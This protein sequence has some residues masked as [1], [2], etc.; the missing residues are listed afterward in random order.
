MVAHSVLSAG[1]GRRAS[2]GAGRASRTATDTG[3]KMPSQAAVWAGRLVSGF[4][5]VFL[6]V[7]VL[8]V[9]VLILVPRVTG[10]QTY[11]VLTSSMAPKYAPGTFIVVRPEPFDQLK[12]GDVITYQIKSGEPGVIT[13]RI[14]EINLSQTGEK[15]LTTMGDNNGA[16]DLDPVTEVQVKGK[17]FYAVPYV[18]YAANALGNSDRSLWL[19]VGAVG[20]IAYGGFT[21]VRGARAARAD[22]AEDKDGNKDGHEA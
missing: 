9:L 21:M 1:T 10:S 17:L 7:A 22:S 16:A 11:S 15:T 14:T 5:V 13:H 19:M 3:V 2:A 12:I 18:G 4:G 8:A 20:L 6:A